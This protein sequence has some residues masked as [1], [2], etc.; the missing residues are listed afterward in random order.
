MKCQKCHAPLVE[1]YPDRFRCG[2][3]ITQSGHFQEAGV[4]GA[5]ISRQRDNLEVRVVE[6]ENLL[7]LVIKAG[8]RLSTCA[9]CVVSPSD[10][11]RYL[12]QWKEA[13]LR[14]SEKRGR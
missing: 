3:Y 9:D 11:I 5:C 1:G 13:K 12:A 10:A 14:I 6:L 4:S 2:S 8:D 7:D